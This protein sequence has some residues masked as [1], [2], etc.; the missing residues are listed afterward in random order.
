MYFRVNL[1][2]QKRIAMNQASA[3]QQGNT[4]A[5]GQAPPAGQQAPPT[6]QMVPP[7][8]QQVPPTY[9]PVPSA[10]QQAPPTYQ[11][12]P[13]AGQEAPPVFQPGPPAGQQP[14]GYAAAP[15]ESYNPMYQAG[16]YGATAPPG[17]YM[18]TGQHTWAT[19]YVSDGEVPPSICT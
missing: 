13:S 7:A 9:Q 10:G 6:F 15:P 12:V 19:K 18:T 17:K 2:L 16:G 11:P 4:V 3:T 8:G 1:I 5:P 14:G